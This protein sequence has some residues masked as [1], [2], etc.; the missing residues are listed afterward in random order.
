MN[1]KNFEAIFTPETMGAL[2]PA[3]RSN[4]F[5]EAL[6]GDVEEGAYDI[7]IEFKGEKK[8]GVLEFVFGLDQRPGKCI[9]C[10]L[11]YG[12]PEVFVRHP[13]IAMTKLIQNIAEKLGKTADQIQWELGATREVSRS[14]H[15]IPLLIRT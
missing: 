9:V 1:Q 7:G 3:E 15:E 13:I 4:A 11:T 8:D 2:F 6:Y 5:F 10:S 14:R 12:L